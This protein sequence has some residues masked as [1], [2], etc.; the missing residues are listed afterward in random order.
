MR[1]R[2]FHCQGQAKQLCETPIVVV[3]PWT[4][5]IALNPFRMLEEERIMHLALELR[6]SWNFSDDIG[7]GGR[8]HLF[9]IKHSRAADAN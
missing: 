7:R 3:A 2:A 1:L 9:T 8:I 5:A 4:V 6:V